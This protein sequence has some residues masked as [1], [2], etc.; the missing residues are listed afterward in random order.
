MIQHVYV[1]RI[2][3]TKPGK[4]LVEASNGGREGPPKIIFEC[5]ADVVRFNQHLEVTI[6]PK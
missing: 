6:T 3:Q 1:K 2:E 4:V 5:D